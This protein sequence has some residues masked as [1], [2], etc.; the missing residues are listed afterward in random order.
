MSGHPTLRR[1]LRRD[2]RRT[3]PLFTALVVTV[4]LGIALYAA[5]N[6]AYRNLTDSY[7]NAF[8]VQ[9]FPDLFVTT[10]DPQAYADQI[11]DDP[12]VQA[13]R[14]RVQADLPMAVTSGSGGTDKL[15]GRIVGYPAN[16]TP[17]VASLTTLSG[18][19]NP[20]P[21]EVL[22]EE[23]MADTFGLE[24]GDSV[25]V[26]TAAGEVE[27]EVA[28]VVSSAEYLWPAP[29]RQE[30]IVPPRSFGVLFVTDADARAW[31]GGGDNQALVLLTDTARNSADAGA[32]LSSLSSTATQ[33]GATEVL[34]RAEQPSNSLLQEDISGFQQMAVAFPALFLTAA[35]LAMYVLLT[36]RVTQERQ[37]IGTLRASGVR[38]RTVGWH[39]LSYGLVAGALGALLGLPLGMAMAGAMSRAYVAVIGLPD[40]LTVFTAFRLETIAVGVAFALVATAISAGFPA[41]RAARVA[42]A[43]AMRGD[44]ADGHART[45]RIERLVPGL[46]HLPARWRMIVRSIARNGKRTVFTASGVVLALILVLASVGMLDTMSSLIRVQFDEVTLAD[47]QVEY[48]APVGTDQVVAVNGVE[49]VT[50][51]E[52]VISQPVSVAAHGSVYS[53][54]I[55]G[56]DPNTRLHGFITRGGDPVPLPDDGIL[57][58][59]AITAAIPDLQPGDEVQ[60]TFPADGSTV[61]TTVVDFTYEPLG[62]F[63][64]ATKDWMRKNVPGAEATTV[65]AATDPG[66]D[67]DAVRRAVSDLPGVVA[68]VPTSALQTTYEQYAGL[69]NVFLGAM[70]LLGAAMAFAIIFTTMSVNI[71]ERQRELATLRAAGVRYR[72]LAG[73]VGGENTVIAALGVVPG[74]VLG[75]VSAAALLQTYSNDQFTLTLDIRWTSLVLAAV[76]IM[77]VAVLSQWP[78]LRS[79]R[80]MNVA[81][82]VRERS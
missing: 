15:T 22:V 41:R 81:D 51:A 68:Y 21:G 9:S 14:T 53:T 82:A 60:L 1:K 5:S 69:F 7:D 11:R 45:S 24:A 37:V 47:A 77:A 64:Y 17:A 66:A 30:I 13:T 27:V 18:A 19:S 65:L 78:G 62:T 56:Y 76:A 29:S 3:W 71:V 59:E 63:A 74:L 80:R 43:E 23:H 6:N 79:V 4:L 58:D 50:H 31:S 16:G 75:V 52:S 28:G 38:S 46:E 55:T 20:S 72:T 36:R 42:P 25:R 35:G 49:G 12:A 57:I 40:Q 8:V 44:G 67:Q 32:A 34:T 39:Y 33:D 26:S 54:Q 48:A 2:I 73:L 61:T 10:P 70:L